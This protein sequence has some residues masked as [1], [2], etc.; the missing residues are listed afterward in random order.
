MHGMIR[1]AEQIRNQSP[2]DC[3]AAYRQN[4]INP[5]ITTAFLDVTVNTV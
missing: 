1:L 3:K 2:N 4:K 5:A